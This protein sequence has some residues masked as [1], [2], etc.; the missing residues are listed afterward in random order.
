MDL[1]GE[2]KSK[3]LDISSDHHSFSSQKFLRSTNFHWIIFAK[4]NIDS[5]RNNLDSP[6]DE[7]KGNAD[8]L[9]V[10]ETPLFNS[11]LTGWIISGETI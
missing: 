4:L 2:C 1:E 6:V 10:W 7:I 9:V 5:L 11:N 3:T 8:I